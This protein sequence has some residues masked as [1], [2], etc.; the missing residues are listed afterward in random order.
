MS[1]RVRSVA[2]VDTSEDEE[3]MGR[4]LLWGK[5]T[6]ILDADLHQYSQEKVALQ[7]SKDESSTWV[8]GA[9]FSMNQDIPVSIWR[10]LRVK[11]GV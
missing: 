2:L 4:G 10:T 8:S 3:S 5:D 1:A 6:N 11:A 7:Y 9:A